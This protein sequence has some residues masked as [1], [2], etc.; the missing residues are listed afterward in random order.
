VESLAGYNILMK[1]P[2]PESSFIRAARKDLIA[3]YEGMKQ[4][5]K[6]VKYRAELAANEPK[7]PETAR[8]N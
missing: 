1:Y 4:P 2:S 7:P 5:E 3:A 8:K 6:A